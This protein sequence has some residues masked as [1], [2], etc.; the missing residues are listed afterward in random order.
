MQDDPLKHRLHD[1][2]SSI[3]MSVY[4]ARRY[5]ICNILLLLPSS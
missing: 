2:P 4:G 1:V 5:V 3:Y